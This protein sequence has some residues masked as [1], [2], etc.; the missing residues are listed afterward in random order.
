MAARDEVIRY[1][2]EVSG[3]KELQAIARQLTSTGDVSEELEGQIRGVANEFGKLNQAANAVRSITGIKAALQET[4]DKLFLAKRGLAE[5]N[6][7]FSSTDSSSKKLTSAF[8]AA[9]QVVAKLTAEE[10]KL[11]LQLAK[12]NGVIAKHGLDVTNLA[13]AEQTLSARAAEVAASVKGLA[14]QATR[15]AFGTKELERSTG[16]ISKAFQSARDGVNGFVGGL[17]RITGVAGA[18]SAAL[19]GLGIGR[20]FG[21]AVTSAR[22]FEGA[23]SEIRAVTGAT[24]DELRDMREAAESS[25]ASTKFSALEAAQALGELARA[26]GDAADATSQLPPTL[27]LAQAAGIGAAEAANILTTSLTQFGLTAADT[28]RVADLFAR[29]ANST[30][31]TVSKLGLAMSYVAPLAKQFGASIED[32]TALLGAL[33]E[34]GFRGERAGTALRNVFG[35]LLD[36]SSKFSTALSGL[37]IKTESFSS[38][39]EGLAAAGD[40]GKRAILALDAEARP[41][42]LALVESGGAG[43]RRLKEDFAA[44]GG[45]AARTAQIMGQNFEGASSRLVGALDYLRRALVDPIL[46]PLAAQ[47]DDAAHRVRAFAETADFKALAATIKDFAVSAA[48]GLKEFVASIDFKAVIDSVRGFVTSAGEFF[49]NLEDN[50]GRVGK[51]LSSV[52]SGFQF[53]WNG[54]QTVVLGGAAVITGAVATISKAAIFAARALSNLN[55]SA[56]AL[57]PHFAEAERQVGALFAVAEEFGRRA[58]DNGKDAADAFGKMAAALGKAAEQGGQLKASFDNVKSGSDSTAKSFA[59][60]KRELE[61]LLPPSIDGVN[62]LGEAIGK[63]PDAAKRTQDALAGLGLKSQAELQL[64]ADAARRALDEVYAGFQAGVATIED[65]KRAFKAYSDAARAAAAD[66]TAAIKSQTESQLA[67]KESALGVG[68]SFKRATSSVVSGSQDAREAVE[69]LGDST[70]ATEGQMVKATDGVADAFTAWTNTFGQQ[71]AAAAQEFMRLTNA[72][73]NARTVIMSNLGD[74]DATGFVR[75]GASINAA[76]RIIEDSIE[77]QKLAAAELANQYVDVGNQSADAFLRQSGSLENASANIDGYIAMLREGRSEFNL[78]GQQSLGPLIA[79]AEQARDRIRQI[80]EEARQAKE[81]LSDMADSYRDQIDQIE[82]N[83]ESQ[84]LRRHERE[85]ARLRERAEASGAANSSEY[86]DA[87]EQANR[88]HELRMRQLREQEAAARRTSEA[89]NAA[90]SS[91]GT[92]STAG[93]ASAQQG[94]NTGGFGALAPININVPGLPSAQVFGTPAQAQ[95]VASIIEQLRRAAMASGNGGG[96]FG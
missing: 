81:E 90:A 19:G 88:L 10:R 17:L 59:D 82:G 49:K 35:A 18:V 78:L 3:S 74:A 2:Y 5:L 41:A 86:N 34:Q 30:Q 70:E 12:A 95:S 8:T 11:E 93:S 32:T 54:L 51:T 9:E 43:I 64:A 4:G 6:A 94:G 25:A 53:F 45:E 55:G 16:G 75:Y 40:Q 42:I 66:S 62:T 60:V 1:V 76:A 61:A 91:G 77:R 26:S 79:S 52:A 15:A 33:A 72:I 21:G 69:E 24:T 13:K 37:N 80:G 56:A 50:A 39:V 58:T 63:I 68:E 31:D 96:L 57:A 89:G 20:V 29:E 87:V 83:A 28:A 65:V 46:Q 67:L 14:E 36:P 23:L 38:I 47:F 7:Q 73:Y 27:N 44:A 92:S 48:Q 84:E 85:L 71:S 22:E